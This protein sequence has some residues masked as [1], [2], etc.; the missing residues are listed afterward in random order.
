MR[1]AHAERFSIIIRMRVQSCFVWS[2]GCN[3][4]AICKEPSLYVKSLNM[5]TGYSFDT[6]HAESKQMVPEQLTGF[7]GEP[8]PFSKDKHG[9]SVL[10][11]ADN[12]TV[13]QRE[14]R[15]SKHGGIS[16]TEH[17]IP[18]NAAWRLK[19]LPTSGEE[20]KGKGGIVSPHF[21][22]KLHWVE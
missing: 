9:E 20:Y 21:T 3:C 8:M 18:V 4:L 12:S 2:A 14:P 10:I 19:L 16:Y 22:V 5:A 6:V 15:E 13:E 17:P 7:L 11:S 1:G